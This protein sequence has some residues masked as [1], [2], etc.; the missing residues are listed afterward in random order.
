MTTHRAHQQLLSSVKSN[1][2]YSATMIC[3]FSVLISTD[4]SG[5]DMSPQANLTEGEVAA[6]P[7]GSSQQPQEEELAI[8]PFYRWRN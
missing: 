8:I 7:L 6:V 5:A 3:L 1:G 2:T 4:R